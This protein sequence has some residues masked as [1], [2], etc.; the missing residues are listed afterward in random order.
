VL[1]ARDIDEKER[2][3]RNICTSHPDHLLATKGVELIVLNDRKAAARHTLISYLLQKKGFWRWNR[4]S[5]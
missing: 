2:T 5:A 1:K 4:Q 3:N